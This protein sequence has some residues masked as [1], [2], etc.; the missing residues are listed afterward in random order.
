MHCGKNH[1]PYS[2]PQKDR[3][4]NRTKISSKVRFLPLRDSMQHCV[5]SISTQRQ[6]KITFSSLF[7]PQKNVISGAARYRWQRLFTAHP[8]N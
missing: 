3:K 5:M 2:L 1:T 7:Y 6:H 4:V 8:L